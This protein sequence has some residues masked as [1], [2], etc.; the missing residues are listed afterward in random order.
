LFGITL[1]PMIGMSQVRVYNQIKYL[2]RYNDVDFASLYESVASLE[3]TKQKI[4]S[5]I[6]TYYPLKSPRNDH[7]KIKRL[8]YKLKK[9]IIY[10]LSFKPMEDIVVSQNQIK[11]SIQDIISRG[12]YDVII[13][14]YWYWG[15]LLKSLPENIIKV[16]DTH[17][18][19]EENIELFN[20]GYYKTHNRYRLAKELQYSLKKQYEYFKY[21]DLIVVNS[22]KQAD[23]F[24]VSLPVNKILIAENGQDLTEFLEYKCSIDND[25]LLFYGSLSNQFNGIAL[26]RI[27]AKIYP[28]ILKLYPNAKLFLVGSGPPYD[29][30]QKY[31]YPN[32]IVTGFIEDI[33]PIISKCSVMLLPLETGSGFRGRV[34]E[35]MAL[36]VPVIGTWN[37]L[38]SIGIQDGVQGYYAESDE[39]IIQKAIMLINNQE[40]RQKLSEESR[41]FVQERYNLEATFGRMETSIRAI[42]AGKNKS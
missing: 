19:V 37:G 36:G 24:K 41:K 42:L 1:E 8:F 18:A 15:Y 22:S 21:S 39:E 35:V 16:I 33:K 14:H 26:K 40:L 4:S 7:N 10:H 20:K 29:I 11:K 5:Y 30:L 13:L 23:I 27:L 6:N 28:G 38:Q 9:H 12:N 34:I 2:A 25:S 31:N 32:M 3:A 17:Y